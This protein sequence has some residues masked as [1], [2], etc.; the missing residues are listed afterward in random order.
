MAKANI[1]GGLSGAATGASLGSF[2]GPI[3]T[4]IGGIGGGLLG[5]FSGGGKKKNKTKQL[6]LQTKEQ[7]ELSKLLNQGLI[8]GEGSFKDLFGEFNQ[9]EFEKGVTQP[10]LKN[11]EENIIPKILQDYIGS[12]SVLDSGFQ[13]AQFK[14]GT[15]LQSDLAK[16]MYQARNQN[17]QNRLTGLQT[18]LGKTNVEN[19][20]QKPQTNELNAILEGYAGNSGDKASKGLEDLGKYLKDLLSSPQKEAPA[21]TVG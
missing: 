19:I 7:I 4:A 18:G 6:P 21:T 3:G 16:L 20:T 2:A 5:L 17:T 12:N 1:G 11:F 15:D 8:S 10:A 14:A 13:K 9:G